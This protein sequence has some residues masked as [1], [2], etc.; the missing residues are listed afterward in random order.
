[1]LGRKECANRVEPSNLETGM[2]DPTRDTRLLDSDS[3][4]FP[5]QSTP[6]PNVI[7]NGMSHASRDHQIPWANELADDTASKQNRVGTDVA[8]SENRGSNYL[9]RSQAKDFLSSGYLRTDTRRQELSGTAMQDA[10]DSFRSDMSY[11]SSGHVGTPYYEGF[12]LNGGHCLGPFKV[13]NP[14]MISGMGMRE[15]TAMGSLG[16]GQPG[17]EEYTN[18]IDPVF[19]NRQYL[20]TLDCEPIPVDHRSVQRSGLQPKF[21]R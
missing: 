20:K 1:M 13:A 5:L 19:H 10:A 17:H 14:A 6:I 7:S 21:E 4:K 12:P 9:K 16:D 8:G 15:G 18:L 3:K 2:A 11:P